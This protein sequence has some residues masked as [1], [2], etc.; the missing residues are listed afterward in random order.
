MKLKCGSHPKSALPTTS[1]QVSPV[2]HQRKYCYHT[3]TMV[4]LVDGCEDESHEQQF[5]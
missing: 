4:T 1:E 2:N 3:N 5:R